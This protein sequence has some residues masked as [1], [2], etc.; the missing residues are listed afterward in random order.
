MKY[1][2]GVI[3]F[4]AVFSGWILVASYNQILHLDTEADL[5]WSN[6][7]AQYQRRFDLVPNL[8]SATKATMV[9]EREVFGAIADARTRYAGAKESGDTGEQIEATQ[10]YESALAR[11]LVVMENYP[12][13]QSNQTVR[14]LMDEITGTENRIAYARSEFN[15]TVKSYNFRIAVFPTNLIAGMFGFEKRKMF[16]GQEGAEYAPD[17]NLEI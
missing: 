3:V 1:I 13:L 11:L 17:V 16:E 12:V 2:L 8:V 6:V 5:A 14:G 10:Q 15:Q 7:E 4:L 9:Q